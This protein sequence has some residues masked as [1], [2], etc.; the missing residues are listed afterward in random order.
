VPYWIVPM[1]LS[2]IPLVICPGRPPRS[3]KPIM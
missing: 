2:T 3:S 1:A